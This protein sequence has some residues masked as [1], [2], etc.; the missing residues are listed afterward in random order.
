MRVFVLFTAICI[1]TACSSRVVTDYRA[2]Y[3]FT[4]LKS[5]AWQEPKSKESEDAALDSPLYRER[6]EAGLG[7]GL[8]SIGLE[9]GTADSAD[10]LVQYQVVS[11]TKIEE[12]YAT[13]GLGY[14]TRHGYFGASPSTT[15]KEYEEGS[16]IIDFF[17]RETGN[18]IW[19]GMNSKRLHESNASPQERQTE[20]NSFIQEIFAEYP[21]EP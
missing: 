3:D 8:T 2:G 18:H 20:I 19:R 10:V 15:V 14:T 21:P 12:H 4:A 11:K 6:L 16:L 9:Q 5:W 17:D 13:L 1:C 7:H